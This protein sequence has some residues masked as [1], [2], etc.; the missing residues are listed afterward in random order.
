MK[1]DLLIRQAF[2]KFV[3]LDHL[4]KQTLLMIFS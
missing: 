1:M 2:Q 3:H 4:A